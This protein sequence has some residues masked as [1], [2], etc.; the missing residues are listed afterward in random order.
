MFK[1]EITREDSEHAVSVWLYYFMPLEEVV[2]Y[3]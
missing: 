3:C 2:S 1:Q